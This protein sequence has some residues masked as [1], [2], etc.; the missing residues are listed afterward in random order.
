MPT[1]GFHSEWITLRSKNDHR[2]LL[3]CRASFPSEDEKFIA[4]V[5]VELID[6]NSGGDARVLH[7]YYD[8]KSCMHT[9]TIAST[10]KDDSPLEG[11]LLN[12]LQAIFGNGNPQVDFRYVEPGDRGSDH[13]DHMEHLSVG[14]DIAADRWKH[15]DAKNMAA[16]SSPS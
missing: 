14:A 12:V 1:R 13:Y 8:D 11:E 16:V 7:V 2:I 4:R 15:H 6:R 10:D 3:E 9:V 5:A